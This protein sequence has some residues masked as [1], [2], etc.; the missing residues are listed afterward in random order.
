M[1]R[2]LLIK[3]SILKIFIL[4]NFKGLFLT[5]P[6]FIISLWTLNYSRVFI[7][8][9]GI[10]SFN[11]SSFLLYIPYLIISLFYIVILPKTLKNL[12][13]KSFSV[14]DIKLYK[15]FTYFLFILISVDYIN[16]IFSKS[17]PFFNTFYISRVNYMETTPFWGFLKYLG[18]VQ[19]FIPIIAGWMLLI[20]NHILYH[21]KNSKYIIISYITYIIL[22]GYKFGGPVDSMIF[23]FIPT[24]VREII[25]RRKIVSLTRL[26]L[27]GIVGILIILLILYNYRNLSLASQFG[28]VFGM[29]YQRIF[30]LQAHTFWGAINIA[31]DTSSA[32]YDLTFIWH[33]MEN[34]MSI[35]TGINISE[36]IEGGSRFSG[37]F[38]GSLLLSTNLYLS[39]IIH[40]LF[41]FILFI[42]T[43]LIIRN[44]YKVEYILITYL[45]LNYRS[46]LSVGSL[47]DLFTP[48]IFIVF[49]FLSLIKFY[50]SFS[51]LI[52]SSNHSIIQNIS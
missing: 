43:I 45:V 42:S 47:S 31:S 20:E 26:I 50:R 2:F 25:D 39:Y 40:G 16:I 5:I 3:N 13:I 10:Y 29:F 22:I 32:K 37:G 41:S 33:G 8:E 9:Q 14:L 27:L 12:Y 15:Y 46:F 11:N 34:L 28:G 44:I 4:L 17:I 51:R 21:K 36:I 38:L 35:L 24:L 18:K 1:L 52:H 49:T 19:L 23:Y 7:S 6:L 48:K 30:S